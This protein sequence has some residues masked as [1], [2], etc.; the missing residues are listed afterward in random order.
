M[1]EVGNVDTK[2]L[3]S[4]VQRIER[5]TEE[6]KTITED[7]KEVYSEAKSMGF[8]KKIMHQVIKLREMD[9]ADREEMELLLETYKR[10]LNLINTD[11]STMFEGD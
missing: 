7:I 10:A 11:E 8:D 1:S 4:F 5:L 9:S 2:Q 6:K 3:E